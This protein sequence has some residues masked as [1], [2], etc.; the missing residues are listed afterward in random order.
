MSQADAEVFVDSLAEFQQIV[1][2]NIWHLK[3]NKCVCIEEI[4]YPPSST[5][6]AK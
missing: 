4:G 6:E 1:I 5:F 3:F 2:L